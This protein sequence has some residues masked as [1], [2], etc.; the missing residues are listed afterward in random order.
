MNP[1][2]AATLEMVRLESKR[3]FDIHGDFWS[4]AEGL[5]VLTEEYHELIEAIRQNDADA[6]RHEAIQVAAVAIRIVEAFS[7]PE[8]WIRSG[9]KK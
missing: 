9:A 7:A 3:A 4:T 6:I 1:Y 8:Y 5:G 2:A